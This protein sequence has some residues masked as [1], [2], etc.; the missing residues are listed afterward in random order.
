MGGQW[1]PPQ[2]SLHGSRGGD[3]AATCGHCWPAGL[4]SIPNLLNGHDKVAAG[5]HRG[6]KPLSEVAVSLWPVLED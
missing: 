3:T 5:E 4:C 2:P 6:W 1:S